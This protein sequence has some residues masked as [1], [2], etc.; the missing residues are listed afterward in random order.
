MYPNLYR[1]SKVTS[2]LKVKYNQIGYPTSH[3]TKPC[4]K[5]WIMKTPIAVILVAVIL[6]FVAGCGPGQPLEIESTQTP[7]S[8][9]TAQV[10]SA[11]SW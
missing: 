7:Q 9:V 4:L 2:T 3:S 8:A 5:G 10:A 11:D 6:F 1:H